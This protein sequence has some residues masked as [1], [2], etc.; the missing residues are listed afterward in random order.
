[1]EDFDSQLSPI[2]TAE[3]LL[4]FLEGCPGLSCAFDT[5]NFRYAGQD[6]LEAYTLL[7]SRVGHVHLK[8]RAYTQSNGENPKTAVDGTDLYPAP[9]GSGDLPLDQVMAR[10]RQDGYNGIY[11]IEH[12]DSNRTLDYL[13]QSVEWVKA[14]LNG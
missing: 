14:Q 4:R 12:Y 8:D 3:G 13:R 6:V 1:M 9:V 11:T 7:R 2:A 10:L 5:G